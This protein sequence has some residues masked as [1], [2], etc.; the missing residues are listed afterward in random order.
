MLIGRLTDFHSK[1][2]RHQT[3]SLVVVVGGPKT[4]QHVLIGQ[5]KLLPPPPSNSHWEAKI[6]TNPPYQTEAEGLRAAASHSWGRAECV[7]R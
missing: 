5:P 3:D 4:S 2:G 1:N 7:W 6:K